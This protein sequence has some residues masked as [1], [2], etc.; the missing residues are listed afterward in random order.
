LFACYSFFKILKYRVKYK[1]ANLGEYLLCGSMIVVFLK[2]QGAWSMEHG[3][4][5]REQG[6]W[7][8]DKSGFQPGLAG[9]RPGLFA[10]QA[11]EMT[12]SLNMEKDC[13]INCRQL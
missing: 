7:G 12:A 4:G 2:K 13:R 11:Y 6:A 8:S 5:S 1:S 10:L 3:A 9:V